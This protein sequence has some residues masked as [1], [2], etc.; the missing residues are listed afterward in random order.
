[1]T[2]LSNQKIEQISGKSA[3]MQPADIQK[4]MQQLPGWK[5]AEQ[6][7]EKSLERTF[8]F[9]DFAS[10]LSFTNQIGKI[11]EEENHHPAI[12]TEWG[13]VKV[14]WWT[15]KIHGLHMNDFIMAARTNDIYQKESSNAR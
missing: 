14:A 11:A 2:G 12:L 3:V 15:H 13:K 1:M 9:P 10:A 4:T 6:E 7:G 8:I 5:L